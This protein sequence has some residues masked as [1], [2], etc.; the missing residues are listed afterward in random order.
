LLRLVGLDLDGTLVDSAPD[1]A[2]ALGRALE[3]LSL[4]PPTEQQTRTWIGD[5]I[6]TL[7][8]RALTDAIGSPADAVTLTTALAAFDE[9]YGRE[10]FVRSTLYP[11]VIPTLQRLR[12]AGLK[13]A[14]ITNKRIAFAEPLLRSAGLMPWLD[15]VY[16][17]DSFASK[18]PAPDQLNAAAK[19]FGVRPEQAVHIGDSPNDLDAARS[20]GWSFLFATYGYTTAMRERGEWPAPGIASFADIADALL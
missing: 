20:A 7:I 2:H 5:G 15:L 4:P 12:E 18:K 13:T 6:E 1:L 3:A 14:C 16:G 19:H 17:G 10:F 8:A 9:C 11:T